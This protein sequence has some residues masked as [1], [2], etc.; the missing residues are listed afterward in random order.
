MNPEE[1]KADKALD[2]G[3]LA[4]ER[5]KAGAPVPDEEIGRPYRHWSSRVPML[6]GVEY[7]KVD[8]KD[9]LEKI[10][11][12]TT[13]GQGWE[14]YEKKEAEQAEARAKR[15][16]ER[17]EKKAAKEVE[18]AKKKAEREAKK[19][20]DAKKKAEKEEKAKAE[21]AAKKAKEAA[22]K[23]PVTKK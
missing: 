20:E 10:R 3:D 18:A 4:R 17:A 22:E 9:E 2:G 8:A 19:A 21:A 1:I 14:N 16:K 11:G 7:K 23:T 13:R 12:I 6:E 15:E 5:Q